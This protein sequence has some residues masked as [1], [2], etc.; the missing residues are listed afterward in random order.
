[1]FSVRRTAV[2]ELSFQW[3]GPRADEARYREVLSRPHQA[4]HQGGHQGGAKW[5]DV[6]LQHQPVNL[7]VDPLLRLVGLSSVP[8]SVRIHL[9]SQV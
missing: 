7:R 1:M 3:V 8:L 5:L 9:R 6:N 4:G 2:G